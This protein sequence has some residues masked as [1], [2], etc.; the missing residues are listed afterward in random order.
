MNRNRPQFLERYM[1]YLEIFENKAEITVL[2]NANTIQ[3]FFQFICCKIFRDKDETAAV[4]REAVEAFDCSSYGISIAAQVTPSDIEDYLFYLSNSLRNSN[5]TCYKKLIALRSFYRYLEQNAQDLSIRLPNGNPILYVNSPSVINTPPDILTVD[6]IQKLLNAA[7]GV[8]SVRDECIILMMITTGI[9]ISEI[10]AANRRDI[11]W[12]NQTLTVR[13][14]NGKKRKLLLTH[15]MI[16]WLHRMEAAEDFDCPEALFVSSKNGKRLTN[17]AIQY[18]IRK[19]TS[20][21]G[22]RNINPQALRNTAVSILARAAEPGEEQ[23]VYSYLGYTVPINNRLGITPPPV[24][25]KCI[26][27]ILNRSPLYNLGG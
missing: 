22:L 18:R 12:D 26:R 6:E 4:T 3:N 13:S 2:D 14:G 7:F 9:T 21:A 25:L 10:C 1:N 19:I 5:A 11:S 24:D 23:M 20:V 15:N 17:R 27:L 8:N 16:R